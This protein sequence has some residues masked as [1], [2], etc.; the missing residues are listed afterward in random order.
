M[1]QSAFRLLLI[2]GLCVSPHG[3]IAAALTP[4]AAVFNDRWTRHDETFARDIARQVSAAG[5]TVE[6]VGVTS[7]TNFPPRNSIW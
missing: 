1:S 3:R 4:R 7:L 6:F 5:Y 2:L